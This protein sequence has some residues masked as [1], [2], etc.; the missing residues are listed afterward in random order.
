M[1]VLQPV[2]SEGS[3]DERY[4]IPQDLNEAGI[5]LKNLQF[6]NYLGLKDEILNTK[7]MEKV[8]FLSDNLDMD[9]LMNIDFKVGQDPSMPRIDR[10]YSYLKLDM[11][12]RDKQK[13]L[14]MINNAKSK[15]ETQ[16]QHLI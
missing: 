3:T 2:Q 11:M 6:L 13:E 1:E 15:W 14:D 12:S 4:A 7:V 9:S 10:I 16:T 8:S 5:N